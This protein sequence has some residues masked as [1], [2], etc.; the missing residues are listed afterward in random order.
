MLYQVFRG[1]CTIIS[2]LGS[3]QRPTDLLIPT[4]ARPPLSPSPSLTDWVG[5]YPVCVC[6]QRGVGFT[7]E[8]P[9]SEIRGQ[10]RFPRHFVG[11][12]GSAPHFY[13]RFGIT[14]YGVIGSLKCH[15]SLSQLLTEVLKSTVPRLKQG[16]RDQKNTSEFNA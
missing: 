4:H 6:V 16:Q 3:C 15:S 12:I 11:G 5:L 13:C 9:K 2:S 10:R 1:N 14:M 8:P 7:V